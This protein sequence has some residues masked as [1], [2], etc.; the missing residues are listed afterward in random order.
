MCKKIIPLLWDFL[1]KKMTFAC[2]YQ[3]NVLSLQSKFKTITI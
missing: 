3:K 1:H 2:I